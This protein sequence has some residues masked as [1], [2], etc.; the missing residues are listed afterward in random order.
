MSRNKDIKNL[1]SVSGCRYS[2][3]RKVLKKHSWNYWGAYAEVQ[4]N[5][6]NH[7]IS[8]DGLVD[9]IRKFGELAE[10]TSKAFEKFREAVKP[11]KEKGVI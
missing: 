9:S 2:Y 8:F 7:I 10:E 6:A 3:L 4:Y 1:K 5:L 11:L